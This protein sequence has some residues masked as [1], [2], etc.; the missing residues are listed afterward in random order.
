MSA[1]NYYYFY[2]SSSQRLPR[3]A[4]CTESLVVPPSPLQLRVNVAGALSDSD[5][6]PLV[7]CVPDQPP[8]AVQLVASVDDQLKLI[9]L[10]R[11]IRD[12]LAVRFTVG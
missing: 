7:A 1:I 3:A 8:E 11:E 10:P 12:G 2:L 4:Y 9:V 6:E 5:R